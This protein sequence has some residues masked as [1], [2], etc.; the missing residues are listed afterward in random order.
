MKKE[1]RKQ[2]S[3]MMALCIAASLLFTG[4]VSAV[5]AKEE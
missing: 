2:V 1:V 5:N 3:A 4:E